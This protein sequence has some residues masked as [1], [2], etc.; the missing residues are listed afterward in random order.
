[1]SAPTFADHIKE[2]RWRFSLIAAVFLGTSALAFAHSR[3]LLDFI[4]APL[5]GQQLIYL[6]VGGG[7]NFVFQVTMAAGLLATAPFVIHQL[8]AF[9]KPALPK[10]AQRSAL[11]MAFFATILLI[12]GAGYAYYVAVPAALQFLSEF[13]GDA[14]TPSLTA[15]SYLS[16]FLSYTAG[17]ALLFQLPLLLMLWHWIS[18]LTPT[19]LLKSERWIILLA[20]IAAAVITPT[21]DIVNQAMLAVPLIVI[22]QFG[23]LAVLLSGAKQKRRLRQAEPTARAR[24]A[25]HEIT[26]AKAKRAEKR[27]AYRL[28]APAHSSRHA[29]HVGRKAVAIAA[30]APTTLSLPVPL[31]APQPVPVPLPVEERTVA[32]AA[33]VSVPAP[34]PIR[35]P[36]SLPVRERPLPRIPA[37]RDNA[38]TVMRRSTGATQQ[39]LRREVENESLQA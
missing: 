27:A 33:P 31:A 23:V 32:V 17:L 36:G 35:Q 22:Y 14:V 12:M 5:Q 9:I 6:T 2:L 4:L 28:K 11:K 13:A 18:P 34:P 39:P 3:D 19:G 20:F 15:D 8:F 24:R 25:K 30:Q 1:M 26:T 16:F 10:E 21:P 29:G 38:I 7:F 37:R